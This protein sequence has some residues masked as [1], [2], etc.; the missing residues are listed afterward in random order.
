MCSWISELP[1]LPSKWVLCTTS[2]LLY[3][4]EC[5]A[6]TLRTYASPQEISAGVP[7]R[8]LGE[9]FTYLRESS[10]DLSGCAWANAWRILYVPTRVLSRSQRGQQRQ[11]AFRTTERPHDQALHIR[12]SKPP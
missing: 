1:T 9:Y 5:L 3:L 6:N 8:M 2:L 4:G 12:W 11:S 10:G 7:G